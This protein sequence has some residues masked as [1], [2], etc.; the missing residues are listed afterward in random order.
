MRETVPKLHNYPKKEREKPHQY[1]CQ[2]TSVRNA[3]V[4][5]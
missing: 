5:V 3:Q 4:V 1:P 2:V